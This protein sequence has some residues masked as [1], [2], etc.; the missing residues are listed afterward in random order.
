MVFAFSIPLKSGD[1]NSE[2]PEKKFYEFKAGDVLTFGVYNK[3]KMEDE[4]LLLKDFEIEED[5]TTKVIMKFSKKE[6][7][8]GPLIEKP[9]PYWYEI[10][11]NHN[12]TV[13]GYDLDGAKILMLY[14][15]GSDIPKTD[16]KVVLE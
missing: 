3:K 11:L 16:E 1:D 9:T 5:G 7:K 4:A 6:M 12:R 10:Q 8:I 2:N 15:E 14:P 13:L